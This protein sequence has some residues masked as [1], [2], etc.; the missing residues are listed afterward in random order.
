MAGRKTKL[1]K[2]VQ[3]KIV[4]VLKTGATVADACRYAG[5]TTTTYYNWIER[6]ETGEPEFLEFLDASTRAQVDA[7]VVAIDTLRNAMSPTISRTRKIHTVTELKENIYGKP[8]EYKKV[9]E[10]ETII[11]M[12]GDWR[13]SVEYLKRRAPEEWSEKHILELGLT[14]ELLKRLEAVAKQAEVPA[15]LLFENMLNAIATQLQLGSGGG[16]YSQ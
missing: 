16:D 8:Y 1:D 14:P 12:P 4:K 10:Y 5:I 3:N 2:T 11:D 9:D 7:K 13:A 6:G 15:S